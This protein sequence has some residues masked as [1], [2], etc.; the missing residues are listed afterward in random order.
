MSE[1]EG[2]IPEENTFNAADN[3]AEDTTG[4]TGAENSTAGS[5]NAAG[6]W[7]TRDTD[8]SSGEYTHS[9]GYTQT[10]YSDA[11]YVH[12]D[13]ETTP[14]RYYAP[15]KKVKVKRPAASGEKEKK[16]EKKKIS[17]TVT[18]LL[19]IMCAI[20]GGII[21]AA[22]VGEGIKTR[23]DTLET[24]LDE[25]GTAVSELAEQSAAE[26]EAEA[27]AEAAAAEAAEKSSAAVSYALQNGV[28][29]ASVYDL[30]CRQVV[31][32]TTEVTYTN[33]FGYTSSSAV[34]GSGF[35][36]SSDGY[37]LTNYH[38]IEDAYS[39]GYKITVMKY[40]GT[41]Y[42]AEIV[43]VEEDNDIAVLKVEATDLEAVTF[44]DS[45]AISVGDDAYAVGNPLGE[46]E[47]TMTF[48][49]VSALN[50]SISTSS[51]EEPINMFQIDAAVNSGNSGGPV[52]DANGK[53]IGI[54]TAKYK[55][56]GVEGIGFA[57]PIN[58]AVSIA[59]DLITKGY[60]TGKASLGVVIDDRYNALYSRYYNMPQGAYVYSVEYGSC[61]SK[62]GL[63]AGDIIT[64]IDANEINDDN[65]ISHVLRQYAYGDTAQLTYYRDGEYFTVEV[66]FDEAGRESARSASKT[67][68]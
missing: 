24:R 3:T 22:V 29:P 46:L 53:V 45:D 7:Y 25:T 19:C 18:A 9:N 40:D 36:V 11:H 14:P 26:A 48:G 31:A 27:A 39:S 5:E 35:I 17:A 34:S 6:A 41:S 42:T 57:I 37:I 20:F 12:E 63:R 8:R 51:S 1:Q 28:S 23:L 65:T 68:Y 15:Q 49:R 61:A 21:G 4:G 60:V 44:G 47:F 2:R 55:S 67:S 13:D 33:F 50:R 64:A 58:D 62:A 59:E 32:I 38:V 10:I 16:K 66:T 43:G 52:Y 56:S 30:A 54:V